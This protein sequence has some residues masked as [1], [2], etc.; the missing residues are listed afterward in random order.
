V[1]EV[2]AVLANPPYVE[3]GAQLS[4]ELAHE[5]PGALFAGP[6][7]LDVIRRLAAAPR[8]ALLAV[9][10]GAGQAT[11]VADLLGGDIE[12]LRDLAGIERVVVSRR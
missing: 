12:I 1:G 9:E 6:D 4:P 8:P 11:A 2:D 3:A 5:P 7:G 10:I